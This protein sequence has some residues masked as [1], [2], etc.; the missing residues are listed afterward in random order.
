[1]DK[2]IDRFPLFF[3]S[4]LGAVSAVCVVIRTFLPAAV[5]PKLDIPAM[6]LLTLVALLPAYDLGTDEKRHPCLPAL[7]GALGFG[8]IPVAAGLVDPSS[9]WK[10]ALAGG[11]VVVIT[12]GLFTS[13]ADRLRSGPAA[14]TTPFLGALCLWLAS[15][16]FAGMIL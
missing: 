16:C 15:Q 4:V 5:L 3:A 13:L 12:T 2:K 14:K 10:Y 8:L 6:V 9:C 7:W 1:M 11:A